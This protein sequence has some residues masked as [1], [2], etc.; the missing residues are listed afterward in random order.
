MDFPLTKLLGRG[1]DLSAIFHADSTPLHSNAHHVNQT[2]VGE[3]T[4]V[5][6]SH[7]ASLVLEMLRYLTMLVLA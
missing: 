4:T 5:S 1:R 2:Q 6:S 7:Q 3:L